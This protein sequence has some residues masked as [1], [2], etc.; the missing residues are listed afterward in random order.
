MTARLLKTRAGNVVFPAYLPVTTFGQKYPL[1]S[2]VRPYLPRLAAGVMVS[3]YYARQMEEQDRPRLPVFVDSGGFVS[4]FTGAAVTEEDGLGVVTV[5]KEDGE[6]D[7]LHPYQVLDYQE[8]V[9]DVAFTLD[10]PIPPGMDEAESRKRHRLTIANALWAI[11][12]KRRRDLPL[13]ACVQGFDPDSYRECAH[14]YR[15]MGFDGL[16]IGGLVPRSG[17]D[18]LVEDIVLSVLD[19]ADGLPV[20]VFGIGKPKTVKTLYELGVDSV[21]SSSYVKAAADGVIWPSGERL[22]D[23]SPTDR[24]HLALCNLA[25]ATGTTLPLSA[26]SPAFTTL[27]LGRRQ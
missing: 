9:A 26:Y 15:G 23:P 16:A 8:Q 11:R 19:E 7:V 20:H 13:Y 4:L 17:D 18:Q 14:A 6:N 27:H 25:F 5:S 1:D 21:D 22:K 10:F 3:H 12:N 2:L 24:L